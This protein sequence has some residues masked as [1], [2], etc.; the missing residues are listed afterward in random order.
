MSTTNHK[1]F[2]LMLTG[3]VDPGG[4]SIAA[5]IGTLYQNRTDGG[6]FAKTGAADSAW[7]ELEPLPTEAQ[8]SFAYQCIGGEGAQVT[9]VLPTARLT[10]GYLPVVVMGA[11]NGSANAFKQF[12]VVTSTQT[13]TQFEIA[14]N[15]DV[16]AGDVFYIFIPSS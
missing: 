8:Q 11:I 7:T 1:G 4:A 14:T 10:N 16:E 3:T 12:R 6:I 9:I 5:P 13:T 15:A 2:A